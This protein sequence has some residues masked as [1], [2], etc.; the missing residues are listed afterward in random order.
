M[1]KVII[2]VA[3]LFICSSSYGAVISYTSLSGDSGLSYSWLNDSF[4]TIYN[5]F[6]G[7]IND[8]NVQDD[9]LKEPDFADEI[10]PRI[11]T[12]ETIGDFTYTGHL[13]AVP[14]GGGLTATTTAGTS[15]IEGY[16]IVTAATDKAYTASKD[17]W[18][19]I[20]INGAFQYEE[21]A[22][23]ASEP[24]TPSNSLLLAT[25][26]ADGTDVTSVTDRRQT[27]PPN[28][29]IYTDYI[30]ALVISRDVTDTEV[31][32]LGVGTIDFGAGVSNGFRR[33]ILSADIDF[34]S[35]GRG[36]LD[37]GS[38][39]EGYYYL[40]A[41]ADDGNTT[42]YEGI[43]STS[44]SGASG[45]EGER[46]VGWCYAPSGSLI[47]PDSIGAYRGVGGDAPNYVR[48]EGT[49]SVTTT[50]STYEE[51]PSLADVK[52]YS[53]G[54]PVKISLVI[55]FSNANSGADN[56]FTVS[57]DNVHFMTVMHDTT[58]NAHKNIATTQNIK[59]LG[60]GTHTIDAKWAIANDTL[61]QN[62][63]V[64]GNRRLM[65]EEM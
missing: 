45:V 53:S 48:V 16:R 60:K 64:Y 63:P 11:R 21:V 44:P 19:Y 24:T 29:R 49:N 5:E 9:S 38:L 28:L 47:S 52:F 7:S 58:G 61:T 23:D 12:D 14:G 13:P 42:T 33:N 18:V 62:A 65:I 25:V 55:P 4:N 41:V 22:T 39:S 8:A 56:H 20:D 54:R 34:G 15:Y 1:K 30:Q 2:L 43:A 32:Q 51:I 50:G 17:T 36:G 27:T 37:T 57:V 6:N 31:V 35:N 10:N 3:M 59:K 26:V 40:Y 46:L